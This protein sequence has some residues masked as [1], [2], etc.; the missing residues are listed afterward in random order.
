MNTTFSCAFARLPLGTAV[1]IEFTGPLALALIR[2]RRLRDLVAFALVVAGVAVL[3]RPVAGGHPA[4]PR[5]VA[6]ALLAAI[7]WAI[8][9]VTGARVGRAMPAATGAAL[10]W[11]SPCWSRCRSASARSAR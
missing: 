8:Y 7:A 4:D 9:I 3:V 5:G 6:F 2:S 10:A 11:A 1:G